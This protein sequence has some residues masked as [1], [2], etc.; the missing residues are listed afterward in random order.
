MKV[1]IGN[2]SL[3]VEER[4]TG[5]VSLVFL[6]YWGGTHRTW[7]KVAAELQSTYR[8]VTYDMRGWGES[9]AADDG[10][11]IS[12]LAAESAALIEHLG[13][14]KYV[15]IGH[16]MGGKVAQLVASRRPQGLIGLILVAPA[17]PTP[18]HLPEAAKEQQIHAYDNRETVLQTLAFLSA[19]I[20]D[21]DTVEQIVQDSLSG[22]PEAKLAWP[23]SA[24]LEDISSEVSKITVPTL[25]LAAELD[26]LDSI[27]Q[28]RREVVAR[29]SVAR[30]EV[31]P[32]SGHLLPIDEPMQTAR[33]IDSFIGQLHV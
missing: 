31:I 2:V 26:R 7:N 20:P 11:S 3:A 18:S 30:L 6:H 28:H 13:L 5:N 23:T 9:S 15:L 21:P 29:I 17:T 14:S 32:H 12:A 22:T 8:I 19:R 25:V 27:E 33:A 24:M 4:G 10:Y 16:S 1:T